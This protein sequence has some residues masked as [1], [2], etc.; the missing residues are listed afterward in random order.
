MKTT[1]ITGLLGACLAVAPLIAADQAKRTD[2]ST[3]KAAHAQDSDMQKAIAFERYKEMAAARQERK[4]AKHPTVFYTNADRS[5]DTQ[6]EE[7][8]RKV[9]PKD[10]KGK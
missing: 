2:D 7:Q 8:G 5:S 3:P 9:I 1:L 4:E 6:N 10:P